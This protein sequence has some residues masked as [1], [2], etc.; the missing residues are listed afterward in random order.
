MSPVN[1]NHCH[2]AVCRSGLGGAPDSADRPRAHGGCCR[3]GRGQ[4]ECD[5]L[6]ASLHRRLAALCCCVV[7]RHYC[8]VHT[9]RRDAWAATSALVNPLKH[10]TPLTTVRR[11]IVSIVI[12]IAAALQ[13]AI[14]VV[15]TCNRY[16]GRSELAL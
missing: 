11:E 9:C 16:V 12:S 10:E 15:V 2:R 3:F 8:L 4:R 13:Y 1:P 5:R 6:C 14:H 7:R